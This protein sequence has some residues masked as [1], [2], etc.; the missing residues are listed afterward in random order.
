[1]MKKVLLFALSALTLFCSCE[2]LFESPKDKL[3]RLLSAHWDAWKAEGKDTTKCFVD[4]AKIVPIEWD[5]MVYV[6]Y[7]QAKN[8]EIITDYINNRYWR[9]CEKARGSS[10]EG[11]HF[12]KN[13]KLVYRISL[14]LDSDNEKGVR[15]YSKNDFIVRD[16]NNAKLHLEKDGRFY[17]IRDLSEWNT[18]SK[19]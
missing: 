18:D 9:E 8:S 12:W 7:S 1:M 13:G 6:R 16:R 19:H 14:W 11:L 10:T 5:T 17:I 3:D 2:R 15:V 4:I